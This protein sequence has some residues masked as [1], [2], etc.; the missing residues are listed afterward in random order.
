M[1]VRKAA[2]AVGRHHSWGG[3][4]FVKEPVAEA[5]LSQMRDMMSA[6]ACNISKIS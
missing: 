2:H 6:T 5:M 1:S 4:G 3:L